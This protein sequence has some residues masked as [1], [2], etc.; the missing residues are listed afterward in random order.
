[1]STGE[2]QNSDKPIIGVLEGGTDV[3]SMVIFDPAALP[4]DYDLT[5]R[6]DP[7]AVIERLAEDQMIYWL[8]TASDGGYNLGVCLGASVP[9][10][11]AEF[12]KHIGEAERFAA[13][14]G[15]LYFTGAEYAFRRND[16]RLRKYPH[17]GACQ[18]I[19]P[20]VYRMALYEMDYPEDFHE[21]LLSKRVSASTLRVYSLM[22]F[23]APVGCVATLVLVVSLFSIAWRSLS[24][25][26]SWS[27]AILPVCCLL[28]L[29]LPIGLSCTRTY[30]HAKRVHLAIQREYP[31]YLACLVIDGAQ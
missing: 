23:F 31:A 3:A 25:W 21:E 17:M 27:V 1:M 30:R 11:L 15:R 19:P 5:S 16:S 28:L 2:K 8:Y 9:A 6:G 26:L 14:T 20:G 13:L 10:E 29:L 7:V 22:G 12:A 18:E 4:E 24:V